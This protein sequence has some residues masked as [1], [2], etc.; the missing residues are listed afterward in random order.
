MSEASVDLT[1]SA[2]VT[3]RTS[4]TAGLIIAAGLHCRDDALQQSSAGRLQGPVGKAAEVT[5]PQTRSRC[6]GRLPP[7]A[8]RRVQEYIESHLAEN[9][10]IQ[11]LASIAG[12]TRA[13]PHRSSTKTSPSS[14]AAWGRNYRR[15]GRSSS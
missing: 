13:R 6:R 2:P 10:S 11:M 1:I 12:L 8:L 5:S 7:R 3:A 9:V 4:A 15:F 14:F